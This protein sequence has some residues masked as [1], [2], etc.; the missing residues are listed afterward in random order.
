MTAKLVSS[1]FELAEDGLKTSNIL[2]R[3]D[4]FRDS[5]YFAQQVA[6]RIARA[7][8]AHAGKPFGTSH[9]L[10]QM[11]E[12]LPADHP[13]KA[14]IKALDMLSP[15]ATKF[16]YPSPVGRIAEAPSADVIRKTL[17]DLE[18]LLRDAKAYVYGPQHGASVNSKPDTLK[19]S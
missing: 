14:R 13:L 19:R 18:T 16:R 17:D 8:L 2:F 4:Q 12:T 6:E 5:S 11:A 15:A 3:E 1:Y 7:L 10:G 9:N